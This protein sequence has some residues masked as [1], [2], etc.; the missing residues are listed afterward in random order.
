ME[1]KS[2]ASAELTASDNEGNLLPFIGEI[3]ALINNNV[4]VFNRCIESKKLLE[5]Y[6]DEQEETANYPYIHVKWIN[7]QKSHE[8]AIKITFD[9]YDRKLIQ[10][11]NMQNPTRVMK[12]RMDINGFLLLKQ[13]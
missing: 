2:G 12:E 11:H 5:D 1:M 3:R 4:E 13:K 7:P 8:F 10:M 6:L 9:Y